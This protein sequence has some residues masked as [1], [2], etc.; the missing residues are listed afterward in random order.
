M[1]RQPEPRD[2]RSKKKASARSPVNTV[3]AEGGC[4][5]AVRV[6]GR[7]VDAAEAEELWSVVQNK[8][9]PRWVWQALDHL[10]GGGLAYAFGSRADEVCVELKKLLTPFGWAHF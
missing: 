8:P 4:P 3:V 5:D 6:E 1:A 10:T 2:W 7:R 9:Q